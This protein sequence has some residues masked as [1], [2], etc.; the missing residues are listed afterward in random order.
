MVTHKTVYT[1]GHSTRTVPECIAILNHYA[2][3]Y[4][5]D[6]RTV[7]KSRHNPQ[8]NSAHLEKILKKHHIYYYHF[9]ELGGFRHAHKDSINLAWRN[10]SFRGFADYMQTLEFKNALE[11]L[12]KAIHTYQVVLMCAE[13]VPWRCHRS[14][15]ADTLIVRGMSVIDIFDAHHAKPHTLTPW[16]HVEGTDVTYP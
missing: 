14:L 6:I 3:D 1:I 5:I 2:I 8:F 15:I 11:M 13:A 10:E 4:V 16:A 7:P 9:K 12:L